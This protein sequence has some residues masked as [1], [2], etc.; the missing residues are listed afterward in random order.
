MFPDV[1]LRENICS[2]ENI[3]RKSRRIKD[4]GSDFRAFGRCERSP[5][6]IVADFRTAAADDFLAV[7]RVSS[8]VRRSRKS[9]RRLDE[10]CD[11]V[12]GFRVGV[13]RSVNDVNLA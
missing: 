9:S 8:A 4:F 1:V 12:A 7:F 10:T 5:S 3:G 13:P 6:I 2:R 11:F